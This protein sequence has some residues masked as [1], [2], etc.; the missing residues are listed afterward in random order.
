MNV[1]LI[2]ILGYRIEVQNKSAGWNGPECLYSKIY[3]CVEF[4]FPLRED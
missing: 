4:L 1:G 3:K 2:H